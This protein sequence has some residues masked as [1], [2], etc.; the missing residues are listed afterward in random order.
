MEFKTGDKVKVIG[1]SEY[2]HGIDIGS[3][4]IVLRDQ[5]NDEGSLCVDVAGTNKLGNLIQT[6]HP[7]DIEII[8]DKRWW[9]FWK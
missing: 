8:E 9:Q 7:R 2:C 3:I 4:A 6:L 5:Y 1:N